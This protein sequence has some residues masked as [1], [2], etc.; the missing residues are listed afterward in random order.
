MVRRRVSEGIPAVLLERNGEPRNERDGIFR[1]IR[2]PKARDAVLVAF[3]PVK[4]SRLGELAASFDIVLGVT[5]E[6]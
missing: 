3:T 5:P 1:G 6:S 2:D 4:E